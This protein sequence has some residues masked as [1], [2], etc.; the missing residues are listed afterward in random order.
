[1]EEEYVKRMSNFLNRNPPTQNILY[2]KLVIY[3][4]IDAAY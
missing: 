1:M 4:H 3:R 2:L